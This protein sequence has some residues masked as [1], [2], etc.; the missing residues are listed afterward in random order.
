M[1]QPTD[2]WYRPII[3]RFADNWY[4]LINTFLHSWYKLWLVS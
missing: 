1:T 4:Q 2:N 3:G